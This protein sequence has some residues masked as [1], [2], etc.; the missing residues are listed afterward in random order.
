MKVFKII[1]SICKGIIIFGG[2]IVIGGAGMYIFM[3][4]E[5]ISDIQSRQRP[6]SYSD[7]YRRR[8]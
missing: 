7:Y 3:L 5:L 4:H 8:A 2:G 6:T 1:L